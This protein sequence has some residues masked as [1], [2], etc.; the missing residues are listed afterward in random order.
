VE[1]APEVS[2]RLFDGPDVV[3]GLRGCV[4]IIIIHCVI[5]IGI[6]VLI[7]VIVGSIHR[8]LI[9]NFIEGISVAI[10]N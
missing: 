2:S 1:A 5:Q 9:K 8:R 7:F 3:A 6:V 4:L 10:E